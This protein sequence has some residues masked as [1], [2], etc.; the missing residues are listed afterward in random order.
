MHN[1]GNGR[2]YDVRGYLTGLRQHYPGNIRQLI[3]TPNDFLPEP[4]EAYLVR[5]IQEVNEVGSGMIDR[6]GRYVDIRLKVM[7]AERVLRY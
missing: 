2:N 6:Q 3:G 5:T 4:D 7:L 1:T